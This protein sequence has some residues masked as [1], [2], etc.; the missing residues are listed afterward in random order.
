MLHYFSVFAAVSIVVLACA[1]APAV[2]AERSAVSQTTS[3]CHQ[4]SIIITLLL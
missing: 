3:R 1:E 2:S 4:Q